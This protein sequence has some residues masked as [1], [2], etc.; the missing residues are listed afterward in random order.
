MDS[1]NRKLLF[2]NPEHDFAL[3]VGD[4]PYTPPAEVLKLRKKYSLLPALIAGNSD[5]I[6]LPPELLPH[7]IE[8]LPGFEE[9]V[10]RNI[11]LIYPSDVADHIGEINKVIP[12]GWDHSVVRFF[13]ECKIPDSFLPSPSQLKDIRK[14]SH[15][16]TS[17]LFRQT[18]AELR[19]EEIL[20]PAKEL[21]SVSEVENYLSSVPYAFFKAPWSSSG[22]G[23][24]VSDHISRKGLMEW[25]H[26]LIR[27]QGS[28][29]AEPSWNKTIDFATEWEICNKVPHFLGLSLFEASS[30]GKYH[31]NVK[32]SQDNLFKRIKD[33]ATAFSFE[34]IEDQ[35]KALE[36]LIAPHYEGFLGIDM[37]ADSNG[38]IN[39]CVEIN[40]RLTMGHLMLQK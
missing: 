29:I 13:K 2:F 28:I 19:N 34:I 8:S 26:G 9:V 36:T 37:L 24:V 25:A 35:K 17:I 4:G 39:S 1:G 6:L 40:L 11:I 33:K 3:A 32:D 31:G 30:R 14:L 12:W 22:R 20:N 18:M 7:K 21:H 5:F 10:E 38:K 27:R 23:I 16:K 15:R